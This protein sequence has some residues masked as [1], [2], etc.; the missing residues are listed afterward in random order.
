M[1]PERIVAVSD[2]LDPREIGPHAKDLDI[3]AYAKKPDIKRDRFNW[4]TA[5]HAI[6]PVVSSIDEVGDVDDSEKEGQRRSKDD[7]K[8][9]EDGLQPLCERALQ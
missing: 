3:G 7:C 2:G 6:R 9:P 5:L 8:T 1:K 4:L